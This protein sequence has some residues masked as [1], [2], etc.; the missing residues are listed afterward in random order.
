[1]NLNQDASIN[2]NFICS[3]PLG[4]YRVLLFVIVQ[5]FFSAGIIQDPFHST[6]IQDPFHSAIIQ[7]P[8]LTGITQDPFPAGIIPD[9]PLELNSKITLLLNNTPYIST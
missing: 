3:L 1:M 2:H 6:I 7:D 8:L 5:R 9:P 4:V